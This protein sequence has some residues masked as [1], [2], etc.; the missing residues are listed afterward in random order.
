M[1]KKKIL[2]IICVRSG[3]KGIKNKNLLKINGKTLLEI[4]ISQAKKSNLL[5]RLIISTDSKKMIA[6]AKKLNVEVPFVRPA[7]LSTDTA[8]EW[9]VWRHAIKYMKKNLN[10][11]ADV[12]TCIPTTSPLRNYRDI[13]I[14]IKEFK[15]NQSKPLITVSEAKRNPFFNMVMKKNKKDFDLIISKKKYSR[16][17]DA[18]KVYDV[19]TIAFVVPCAYVLKND[20][21]F[22]KRVKA[23]EFDP[24]KCLDIDSLYEYNL[25]KLQLSKKN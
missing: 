4:A 19:S 22:S 18:P 1:K 10:Y 8:K 5:D 12:L 23:L 24:K 20:H 2:G 16:R 3:S 7:Y 11:D 6:I 21:L 15:K 9:Q 13:D 14:C 25:A 17:Q